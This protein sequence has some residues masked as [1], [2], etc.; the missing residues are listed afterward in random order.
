M[1]RGRRREEEIGNLG[2]VETIALEDN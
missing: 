2:C 1:L